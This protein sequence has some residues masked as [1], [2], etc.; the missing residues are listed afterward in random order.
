LTVHEPS[1]TLRLHEKGRFKS[2]FLIVA[3][4]SAQL[5][6]PA[7]TATLYTLAALLLG[8]TLLYALPRTA[9]LDA[10]LLT[11][12]LGGAVAIHVRIGSPLSSHTLFGVYVGGDGLGWPVAARP[13][14]AWAAYFG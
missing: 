12:Y 9:V 1:S 4:T 10:L 6:W 11:G 13:T 8:S 3:E 5:G 14:A 7:G 2:L